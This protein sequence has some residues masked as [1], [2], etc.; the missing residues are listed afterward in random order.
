MIDDA[1][2]INLSIFC[3]ACFHKGIILVR[4]GESEKGSIL[5]T[6]NYVNQC[7]NPNCWR[8]EKEICSGWQI[9]PRN[10]TRENLARGVHRSGRLP[11][12]LGKSN[13]ENQ[14]HWA[15][16]LVIACTKL[17]AVEGKGGG[18]SARSDEESPGALHDDEES[19]DEGQAVQDG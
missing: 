11:E 1:E 9:E 16:A 13:A 14:A 8:Y 10:V 17:Y 2:E 6:H 18:I 4:M 7:K 3:F 19:G 15:T 5:K 12:P